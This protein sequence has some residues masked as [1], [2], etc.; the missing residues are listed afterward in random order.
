MLMMKW[1]VSDEIDI[2]QHKIY[3]KQHKPR[4]EILQYDK[5]LASSSNVYP[6]QTTSKLWSIVQKLNQNLQTEVITKYG[7][8]T[9]VQ[10]RDIIRQGGVLSRLLYALMMDES[11]KKLKTTDMGIQIPNVD[12]EVPSLL[13][14][15]DVALLSTQPAE[16]REMLD[17]TEWVSS[18]QRIEYGMEKLNT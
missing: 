3:I 12:F 5:S 11:S 1:H 10:I 15:D 14:M 9:K 6:L 8:T 16:Q 2:K 13:G 17:I 18:R 4:Y 7:P